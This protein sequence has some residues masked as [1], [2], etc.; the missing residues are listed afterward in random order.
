MFNFIRGFLMNKKIIAYFFMINCITQA[1]MMFA[2]EQNSD[3]TSE[4]RTVYANLAELTASRLQRRMNECNALVVRL[5][6]QGVQN[7][8]DVTLESLLDG[9][10]SQ[11]GFENAQLVKS[12]QKKSI[13]IEY[14]QWKIRIE[15]G[16]VIGSE[17]LLLWRSAQRCVDTIQKCHREL[18]KRYP[19]LQEK[20]LAYR[21]G[22]PNEKMN[23]EQ[24]AQA[25]WPDKVHSIG[26]I[27][28][29]KGK[30]YLNTLIRLSELSDSMQMS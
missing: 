21:A 25:M 5:Q 2:C 17:L 13:E 27:K 6:Q 22:N 20:L 3:L 12:W 23:N 26:K 10:E 16:L 14:L 8:D 9:N 7:F 11:Y 19:E 28:V 15:S 4:V 1:S 30:A 24:I 29:Q 18:D